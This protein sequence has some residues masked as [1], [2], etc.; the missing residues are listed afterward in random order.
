[1]S[2][3]KVEKEEKR[4]LPY[5]HRLYTTILTRTPKEVNKFLQRSSDAQ[6]K[7]VARVLKQ[8]GKGELA[9]NSKTF[10][11]EFETIKRGHRFNHAYRLNFGSDSK[12][13]RLS[14]LQTYKALIRAKRILPLALKVYLENASSNR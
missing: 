12:I 5:M 1:M 10:D 13:D 4:S 7:D 3:S 11:K 6:L 14:G 9:S 8:F 2:E